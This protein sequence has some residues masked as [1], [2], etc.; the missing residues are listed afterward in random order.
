M[1]AVQVMF[2]EELLRRLAQSEEVRERGRSEV[3][4]RAVDDYLR[5][6][7]RERISRCYREAYSDTEQLDQELDGWTEVGE[8]PE[9]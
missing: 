4:R 2:D 3:V 6:R 8:W 5:R 7:E 1:K 9:A